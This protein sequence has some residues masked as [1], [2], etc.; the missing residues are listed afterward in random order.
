MVSTV[1]KTMS[2]KTPSKKHHYLPVKYLKGFTDSKGGFVVYDK[3]EDNIFYLSAE[4]AFCENNL[5]TVVFPDGERSD[6]LETD[7]Y[8]DM[9]DHSWHSLD[10][11]RE[12]TPSA[13]IDTDDRVQLFLFLSDLYWRLPCNIE[14]VDQLSGK[15]F[16]GDNELDY[17]KLKSNA[18]DTI[19]KEA[20]EIITSSA[21]FKKSA[22]TIIPFTPFYKDRDWLDNLK[23]WRFYY[24]EDESNWYIVGDNPFVTHGDSDHDPENCLR[25]FIFPISGKILLVSV[26]RQTDKILPP[27]FTLQFDVAIVQRSRRFVACQN[28]GFL[29]ALVKHYKLYTEF[30]RAND[31]VKELFQMLSAG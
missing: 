11:V 6:F 17:W 1:G 10:R 18:S 9:E 5:N 30:E 20:I 4:K 25:E 31:I 28:E 22:K 26:D 24:T 29:K 27:E 21:V 16:H 12:S 8:G 15:F 13:V 7:L 19:M 2:K 3:Q 14:F 23:R